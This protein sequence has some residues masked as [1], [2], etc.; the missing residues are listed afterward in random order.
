MIPKL[1]WKQLSNKENT[2]QLAKYRFL[3][4]YNDLCLVFNHLGY[5]IFDQLTR[6]LLEFYNWQKHQLSYFRLYQLCHYIDVWPRLILHLFLNQYRLA[7]I[8]QLFLVLVRRSIT[9]GFPNEQHL[10]Q[11]Y[12]DLAYFGNDTD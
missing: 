5:T 8:D 2:M 7:Q 6:C 11:S 12:C 10:H 3:L 4:L 1:P 9:F